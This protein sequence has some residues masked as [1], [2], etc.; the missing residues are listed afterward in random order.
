M[1]GQKRA[2][3][4]N[5]ENKEN[6]EKIAE[7]QEKIKEMEKEMARIKKENEFLEEAT[8][9]GITTDVCRFPRISV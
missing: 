4:E 3:R 1:A 9:R 5:F 8:S 6:R 7:L 2:V